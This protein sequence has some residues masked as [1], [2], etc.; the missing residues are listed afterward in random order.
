MAQNSLGTYKKSGI[1][2]RQPGASSFGPT[3]YVDANNGNDD[4]LGTRPDRAVATIE[5]GVRIAGV[6]GVDA[7]V[8]VRKGYYAPTKVMALTSD[9]DGIRIIADSLAPFMGRA[10]GPLIYNIGGPDDVFT[11]DGAMN[12]EIAG[13]RIYPE[14]SPDA[15]CFKIAD[16]SYAYG[17]WIHDNVV[18]NVEDSDSGMAVC[19]Q[20]GGTGM[21][22]YT[23]IERNLFYCGGSPLATIKKGMIDW[24]NALWSSVQ[25]NYFHVLGNLTGAYGIKLHTSDNDMPRGWILDNRFFAGEEDIANCVSQAIYNSEALTGGDFFIDGNK[26]VNFSTPFGANIA[27]LEGFGLNYKGDDAVNAA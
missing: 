23:L 5:E 21:A 3:I 1:P 24:K 14:M 27:L 16:A 4:N 20:M 10:S 8:V 13:F 9:H 7:T 11:F 15:T 12:A 2:V 18:Y 6:E 26:T 17:V 22:N 25:N 19:V